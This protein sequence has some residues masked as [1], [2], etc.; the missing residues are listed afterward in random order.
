MKFAHALACFLIGHL[1]LHCQSPAY[2][3]SIVLG[4]QF[5]TM[6][7]ICIL[8]DAGSAM[9]IHPNNGTP[10]HLACPQQD[11]LRERRAIKALHYRVPREDDHSFFELCG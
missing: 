9:L 5:R 6:T 4:A 11:L 3:A 8:I 2:A 7:W 10:F 1:G